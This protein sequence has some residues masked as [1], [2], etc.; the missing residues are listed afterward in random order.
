MK[1]MKGIAPIVVVSVIVVIVVVAAVGYIM[2][3][4]KPPEIA[5]ELEIVI[6]GSLDVF[7]L[8]RLTNEFTKDTGI[9][10]TF[11]RLSAGEMFARVEAEKDAPKADII[12]GGSMPEHAVLGKKGLLERYVSPNLT[13]VI[14][15]E[16]LDPEGYTN[17]FFVWACGLCVNTDLIKKLKIPEPETWDDLLKPCYKGEILLAKSYTSSTS[18]TFDASLLLWKGEENGWKYLKELHKNVAYYTVSGAA[19]CRSAAAGER[20]IGMSAGH[21]I[22]K[23]ILAGYKVKLIYPKPTG[24]STGAVS[25]IKGGPCTEGAKKFV[26]WCFTTSAQQVHADVSCRLGTVPG[27]IYPPGV[28]ALENLSL[29]KMDF[30]WMSANYDIIN[31]K[32][33]TEVELAPK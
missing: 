30:D 12:I 28:P 1:E 20:V 25:I 29:I 31:D 32:W 14:Y 13:S 24:W 2:L 9:K 8:N 7:E 15:P 17:P 10:A 33:K 26:D 22:L 3:T 16:L 11:M 23:L 19:P 18:F 4:K 6:R 21:D 5:P 27:I